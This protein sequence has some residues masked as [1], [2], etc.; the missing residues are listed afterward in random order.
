MDVETKTSLLS[1]SLP[2]SNIPLECFNGVPVGDAFGGMPHPNSKQHLHHTLFSQVSD[3]ETSKGM[4][5]ALL[6]LHLLQDFV[7]AAP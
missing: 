1:R 3:A 2:I 6:L 7:Q 4:K 5:P